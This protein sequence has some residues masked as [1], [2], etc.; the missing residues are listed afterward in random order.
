MTK[1]LQI[2]L[3]GD[4]RLTYGDELLTSLNA[5]RPQSLLAY[6]LLHRRA[7]QP[8][9]HIAFLLWPDSSE[10]QARS[11]LRNLLHGLR[12]SLPDADT[13]LLADTLTLQWNPDAPFALDVA[14]F[15][16]ALA[17][18][19][20]VTDPAVIRRHLETAV[21]CYGGD[22]LPGNYDDWILALREE[23]RRRQVD[24]LYQLVGL[25]EQA[26]EYRTAQR[27]VQR[28]L[29]QD[30]LDE[31]AYVLQ[32]RLCALSGDR[33]GIRR[34]YHSC[35]D[36][37]GRELD[38]EPSPATQAA[39][40]EYL[41]L[42][43]PASTI[44]VALT[45]LPSDTI[46]SDS[47]TASMRATG[48]T[49]LAVTRARALPAPRTNFLGR[50]RELAELALHL[51]EPHCRLLTV[52]GPG[53]VGKTRLAL[54]TAKGHQPVFADGVA[55]V[56]LAPLESVDQIVTAIAD[57]LHISCQ[58]AESPLDQLLDFLHDKEMLLL[59]DNFEHLL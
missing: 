24:A 53:G 31:A 36:V 26:G 34:A 10:S 21:D 55:F 41:R 48:H 58:G 56:P 23:L 27:Y 33:T 22:L 50:K 15:D 44:T 59:L 14:A 29:L 8:R 11:N 7:P 38:V 51:A 9:Q 6:L 37:L 20:N 42:P 47:D 39:Y 4:F 30:P 25:L 17:Q 45:P 12:Q 49:P 1:F 16:A 57:A 28:L 13:F 43:P 40:D 32:M 2:Q 54:E 19:V 3:L 18:A 46:L 35:V 52:I 5:E